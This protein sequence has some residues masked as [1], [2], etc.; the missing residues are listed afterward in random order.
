MSGPDGRRGKLPE[1]VMDRD[2]ITFAL[3]IRIR[4]NGPLQL[5]LRCD[6]DGEIY[7]SIRPASDKSR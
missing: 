4:E 2:A 1:I 6:Q 7:T 5:I 3:T